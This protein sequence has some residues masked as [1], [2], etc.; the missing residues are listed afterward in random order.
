MREGIS[1]LDSDIFRSQFFIFTFPRDNHGILKPPA[2]WFHRKSQTQQNIPPFLTTKKAKRKR[3]GTKKSPTKP[4]SNLF[5][6]S[7]QLQSS[8]IYNQTH[9]K[10]NHDN[11]RKTLRRF[12]ERQGKRKEKQT[13]PFFPISYRTLA[14]RHGTHLRV[15]HHD[16]EPSD[17]D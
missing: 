2:L 7:A 6:F 1:R 12:Q 8:P 10:S 11:K 3:Q 5:F 4:S 15:T 16:D 13:S 14:L 17:Q 9:S